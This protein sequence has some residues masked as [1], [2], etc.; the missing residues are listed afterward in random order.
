MVAILMYQTG[1]LSRILVPMFFPW[2]VG[3]GV[4][5]LS[6]PAPGRRRLA[7][8]RG[9]A[10]RGQAEAADYGKTTVTITPTAIHTAPTRPAGMSIRTRPRASTT[11]GIRT[12]T[13][14]V[15]A[16]GDEEAH[17]HGWAPWRYMVIA[18]PVFLFFLGLPRDGFSEWER[19]R[20]SGSGLQS[21]SLRKSV[22]LLAGGPAYPAR[23][24]PRRLQLRFNELTEAAALP[25][26]HE[27]YEGDVGVIRGQFCAGATVTRVLPCSA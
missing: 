14:P 5:I 20:N 18:I 7:A 13:T 1:M 19:T 2:V 15:H 11:M 27:A 22:A 10:G 6:W 8:G 21:G 16:G 17:D 3:G 24:Q 4:A 9:P 23:T 12:T 25:V 26:R